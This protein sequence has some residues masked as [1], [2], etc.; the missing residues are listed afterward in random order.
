MFRRV[1]GTTKFSASG[2]IE[3]CKK[4]VLSLPRLFSRSLWLIL[5]L[6]VV[7]RLAVALFEGNDV[8]P[9][10]GTYDQVSYHTLATRLLD[11]Y[12]FT[13]PTQW[14]PVTPAGEPTAHWSY[15]YTFYLVGVYALCGVKPIVARL[16]QAIL[17]GVLMPWL[18]YRLTHRLFQDQHFVLLRIT[19]TPALIAAA[20]V[21]FHPYLIYYA[22]SLMTETFHII[23]ILWALD[24]SLRLAYSSPAV[25]GTRR[26]VWLFLELGLAIG[27]AVLL[28]QVFLFFV[29][30][31]FLWLWWARS[32][33]TQAGSGWTRW[34]GAF[35]PVFMGGLVTLLVLVA[36]I[37]PFT[38]LNYRHFGRFV[39]LNTNAGYAFFW[40]NHPVHGYRFVY[41]FTP[42][43]PSYQELIPQE[44]RHLN[45]A[46]LEQ[47]L[48]Q[49]GLRFVIDDP[50]R[51]VS[52]TLSRIPAHFVFWPLPNS[53]LPSNIIRV[54]SFGLAL[55]FM[56]A[57]GI[58]WYI[59]IRRG[60]LDPRPG[61]LLVLFCVVYI[62]VHLVSWAGIRYRLPTDAVSLVF[63]A[64]AL[65]RLLVWL[66]PL[67][68]RLV[69]KP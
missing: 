33:G 17:A 10:P 3:R 58:L 15:L 37:A 40:A 66:P 21:A 7:S 30:F 31:L 49:R 60:R 27:C 68:R 13:M 59:E 19:V 23:A 63:A 26:E 64:Y 5:I 48:M 8:K 14:W 32:R 44:L 69:P 41:L 45:E 56:I 38:A 12:G 35:R 25:R 6:A 4:G 50:V 54:I 46:A 65:W 39:L 1:P 53:S 47:V 20:W 62:G 52:L 18:A 16:I 29:P 22:G 2:Y 9:L 34:S 42:D 11:G 28:R 57:G 67:Q 51:F 36:M 43:M 24:C 55:P 61:A